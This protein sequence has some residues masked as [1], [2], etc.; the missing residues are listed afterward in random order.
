MRTWLQKLTR[1][2][3]A[4]LLPSPSPDLQ[5]NNTSHIDR[6]RTYLPASVCDTFGTIVSTRIWT[7]INHVL[8][9]DV[10]KVQLYNL[11]NRLSTRG[12]LH[13][14]SHEI[15]VA[16]IKSSKAQ[17][18]VSHLN[19]LAYNKSHEMSNIQAFITGFTRGHLSPLDALIT[20]LRVELEM[21]EMMKSIQTGTHPDNQVCVVVAIGL[22]CGVLVAQRTTS[23]GDFTFLVEV[24]RMCSQLVVNR[25][26]IQSPLCLSVGGNHLASTFYRQLNT[27]IPNMDLFSVQLIFSR[28]ETYGYIRSVTFMLSEM[29]SCPSRDQ[30]EAFGQVCRHAMATP[31][32]VEAV[33]Q[34]LVVFF[35]S[36]VHGSASIDFDVIVHARTLRTKMD[37][38]GLRIHLSTGQ[39]LESDIALVSVVLAYVIYMAMHTVGTRDDTYNNG[40]VDFCHMLFTAIQGSI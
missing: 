16:C 12:C 3:N 15:E 33:R 34:I 9:E 20:T 28:F 13:A 4:P 25:H 31:N 39:W 35:W 32:Y 1:T 24:I 17:Q 38:V 14:V 2:L 22:I 8:P 7:S 40:T 27:Y 10:M 18:V 19:S 21:G 30:K 23:T 5:K 29:Q 11:C 37:S 36:S 26:V 6:T